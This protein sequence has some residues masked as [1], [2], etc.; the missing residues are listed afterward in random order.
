MEKEKNNG[1]FNSCRL[2]EN[3]NPYDKAVWLDTE[4]G[5]KPY[6]CVNERIEWYTRYCEEKGYVTVG[7]A[8]EYVPE[9]T[10]QGMITMKA[11]VMVGTSAYTGYGSRLV[12]SAE[13]Y[14]GDDIESAETR[15]IGRALRNAGFGSPFDDSEDNPVDGFKP[16][17][18]P[19]PMSMQMPPMT[20]VEKISAM[21]E[22]IDKPSDAKKAKT[23]GVK[24]EQQ[25]AEM[26]EKPYPFKPW[27]KLPLYEL[28]EQPDL[29]KN[30]TWIANEYKGNPEI[31]EWAK[32]CL[33]YIYAA[34]DTDKAIYLA[35][36]KI[37]RD[38]KL[39]K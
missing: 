11:T 27:P 6:L 10:K 1:L 15:A 20:P 5:K 23:A 8:T 13:G 26:L 14:S 2:V 32:T 30:L 9:L 25:V 18:I 31:A 19:Q 34:D 37:L 28:L 16:Q 29:N 36:R 7:I 21:T 38:N 4:D 24:I 3:Y 22:E 17:P 35:A 12:D 39:I 33:K